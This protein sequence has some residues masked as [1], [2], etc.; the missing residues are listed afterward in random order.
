M[1]TNSTSPDAHLYNRRTRHNVTVG[2][3]CN[4][5]I[6]DVQTRFA[7]ERIAAGCASG[8][9]IEAH[10]DAVQR[11]FVRAFGVEK[12]NAAMRNRPENTND[13]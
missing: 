6:M 8:S 11:D 4:R 12:F 7:R 9:D 1:L 5:T 13:W 10:G 2:S 3:L